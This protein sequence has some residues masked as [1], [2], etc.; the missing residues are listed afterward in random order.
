MTWADFS[1]LISYETHSSFELNF[2]DFKKIKSWEDIV[3]Y[4]TYIQWHPNIKVL[5][6][7]EKRKYTKLPEGI[8]A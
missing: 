6:N 1:D 4:F 3:E 8:V 2:Y 7:L 5:T